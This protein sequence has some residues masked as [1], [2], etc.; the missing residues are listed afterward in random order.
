MLNSNIPIGSKLGY[1]SE[2]VIIPL[3]KILVLVP[4]KVQQPPKMEAYETGISNLEEETPNCLD[5]AKITGSKT[6]TTGVLFTK[7]E[8]SATMPSKIS[9]NLL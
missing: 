2:D 3:A 5:R 6:T 9:M 7:A 1:T 8:I 4:T